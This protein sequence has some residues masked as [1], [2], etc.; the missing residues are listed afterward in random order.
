VLLRLLVEAE[1]DIVCLQ[2][3]IRRVGKLSRAKSA[4]KHIKDVHA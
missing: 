1:P 3:F 4:S 2:E